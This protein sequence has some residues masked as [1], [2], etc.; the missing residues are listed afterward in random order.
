[1][2]SLHRARSSVIAVALLSVV[3]SLI[4]GP[5]PA[6]AA[7]AT[8]DEGGTVALRE[9]LDSANRAFLDA[10]VKLEASKTR[11]AEL[12][13]EGTRVEAERAA[14]SEQTSQIAV[15]AYR[16]GSLRAA[17][18]LLNSPSPDSLLDKATTINQLALH[19]DRVLRQYNELSERVK[20]T[21]ASIDAEVTSQQQQLAAMEAQKQ[22]AERAL[23]AVGGGQVASGV[24]AARPATAAA[25]PRAANGTLQSQGCTADD[26][27]TSGCLTARTLNALQQARAAGFTRHT[28]CYRSS[29][30]G[31]HPRG[32]ACDFSS[33]RTTFAGVATGDDRTYG[34]NL[35]AYFVSNAGRLGVLYVIWFRQIWQPSTGWR[36]YN[37]GNGDPASDHTNHVHLSMI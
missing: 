7:P 28:S 30:G 18:A 24:S 29:G 37:S 9:A 10:Q 20:A 17:S 27:T 31:E 11:Q 5:A 25:A 8:D 34:N 16:A 36:T 4:V 19:N 26:P 32:R 6:G 13:A 12:T 33:N 35:A 3:A 15:A 21:K 22:Q 23:K 1:M 14:L 2:F